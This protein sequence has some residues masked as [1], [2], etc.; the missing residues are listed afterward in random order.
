M[1]E[2]VMNVFRLL[3]SGD[4]SFLLY[5][6]GE[7]NIPELV[8]CLPYIIFHARSL[9][10]PSILN[11]PNALQLISYLDEDW[12]QIE[13]FFMSELEICQS[14]HQ[15]VTFPIPNTLVSS[16]GSD[17]VVTEFQNA[18]KQGKIRILMSD[19]LNYI[20]AVGFYIENTSSLSSPVY[21]SRVALNQQLFAD[22]KILLPLILLHTSEQ[23]S[24]DDM[25]LGFLIS[26]LRIEL[27]RVIVYS[28]P[29]RLLEIIE[30]IVSA[31]LK[32][33]S[34]VR[35]A[36]SST[37]YEI[38]KLAP[39]HAISIRSLLLRKQVMPD[40]ILSITVDFVHDEPDILNILLKGNALA[41]VVDMQNFPGLVAKL[42]QNLIHQLST[43]IS[44]GS[45]IQIRLA[46]SFRALCA[47][48]ALFPADVSESRRRN[49][50][51]E[52]QDD[53]KLPNSE[54]YEVA[55][56]IIAVATS[57]RL[58]QLGLSFLI[59]QCHHLAR[60]SKTQ[61]RQCLKNLIESSPH[62]ELPLLLAV[63]SYTSQS[64]KLEE[65]VSKL[66]GVRVKIDNTASIEMQTILRA[67]FS[68]TVL[69]N[70]ALQLPTSDYSPSLH[71]S[72]GDEDSSTFPIVCF[73]QFLK[74][75]IFQ[76]ACIDIQEW[77]YEKMLHSSAPI[78]SVLLDLI[79]EYVSAI[80]D[81]AYITHIPEALLTPH[82]YGHPVTFQPYHVLLLFYI[83]AYTNRLLS[84][85]ESA[86]RLIPYSN[87]FLYTLPVAKILRWIEKEDDYRFVYPKLVGLIEGTIKH[88]L[89]VSK[90]LILDEDSR[91]TKPILESYF[92]KRAVDQSASFLPARLASRSFNHR[93]AYAIK[94]IEQI[95]RSPIRAQSALHWLYSLDLSLLSPYVWNIVGAVFPRC[96]ENRVHDDCLNSIEKIWYKLN[97]TVPHELW[98][99][100]VNRIVP[101]ATDVAGNYTFLDI[102]TNP[103]L[104]FRCHD[105]VFRC[106]PIFRIF[107]QLLRSV[108]VV[109]R[110]FEDMMFPLTYAKSSLNQ[111]AMGTNAPKLQP[112]NVKALQYSQDSAALQILLDICKE[113][114]SDLSNY[115]DF[116][117]IR[118]DAT[119]FLHQAFLD[120]IS[121]V[122]LVNFQTYDQE[123][124][125]FTVKIP[126]F[127]TFLDH[128]P[129]L[130]SVS[131]PPQ[132]AFVYLVAGKL[133][134]EFPMPHTLD[135]TRKCLLPS[136]TDF[137]KQIVPPIPENRPPQGIN[138]ERLPYLL[139]AL[140]A[141]IDLCKAFPSIEN[142]FTSLLE[143]LDSRTKIHL[144]FLRGAMVQL[145]DPN[146]LLEWASYEEKIKETMDTVL[147]C[148]NCIKEQVTNNTAIK[149][150]SNK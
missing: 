26:D 25:L 73:H 125:P 117:Q 77:V 60:H 76:T 29:N 99:A 8:D 9:A 105:N 28:F 36:A 46:K 82:F 122:K 149:I 37:I 116:Q 43:M 32:G 27:I 59:T 2:G 146:R 102:I 48:L 109:S 35:S 33:K 126:T 11:D 67:E 106:P 38:V 23:L 12:D 135:L 96:Y 87:H 45:I 62:S 118:T 1:T 115:S 123:L 42:Q 51:T 143:D 6:I 55:Y 64:R 127:H 53:Q 31:Y 91:T 92:I 97:L 88:L 128:I 39:H 108:L 80:F 114:P 104:L 85:A 17:N 132:R 145:T 107:L 34:L 113:R 136:L 100:T 52:T 41:L 142:E 120:R 134:Q 63:Y 84:R 139:A 54:L 3:E 66:L 150:K 10:P 103:L 19:L 56:K 20:Q 24:L 137:G 58:V 147:Y 30:S 93:V 86:L 75:N 144:N 89:D 18:S 101:K 141:T 69:A 121:L 81:S 68:T 22:I 131:P 78:E 130:A 74:G 16:Y 14:S 90:F 5:N 110:Q 40:L 65:L 79:D 140:P 148:K 13:E 7:L 50:K 4:F 138:Y 94:S 72:S 133:L 21:I 129:E 124:I 119:L 98:V 57:E 95:H 47:L 70:R 111:V 49:S 71:Y 15:G 61:L 83:L 44:S 112:L